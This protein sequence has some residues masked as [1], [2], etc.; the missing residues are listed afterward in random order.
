MNNQYSLETIASP[1]FAIGSEHDL[2]L[3]TSSRHLLQQIMSHTRE[4]IVVM[5][6]RGRVLE[7]NDAF[8]HLTELDAATVTGQH[9]THISG[10]LYPR[11]YYCDLWQELQRQEQWQGEMQRY[12]RHGDLVTHGLML[13]L[14]R[15]RQAQVSYI[16]GMLEDIS[17]LKDS[18]AQLSYLAHHDA[19]TGCANRA[20]LQHWFNATTS[21]TPSE[22]F[23]FLFID[24]DRFKPINDSFGHEVGD[25]VLTVLARRL[26]ALAD[27]RDLVTRLGGDEF[28]M[29]YRG[30]FTDSALAA[31]AQQVLR[32]LSKPVN[33]GHYVLNLGASVGMSVYPRDGQDFDSLL[34][35]ADIAMYHAKRYRDSHFCQFE[36]TF[37]AKIE[38]QQRL[39]SECSI[40]LEQGAFFLQYQPVFSADG[41]QLQYLEVLVRWHHPE[42]GILYPEQILAAVKAAGLLYRLSEWV[43]LTAGRQLSQWRS[44][45][46]WQGRVSIN[47]SRLE[48]EQ[49]KAKQLLDQLQQLGVSPSQ[50]NLELCSDYMMDCSAALRGTVANLRTAG[51]GIYLNKLGLGAVNFSQLGQLSLDGIK[52]DPDLWHAAYAPWTES[53]ISALVLLAKVRELKVTACGIEQEP[54]WGK[55][56]ALGCDHVQGRL[57]APPATSAALGNPAVL[58]PRTRRHRSLWDVK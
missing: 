58:E 56:Q 39:V 48:L 40:A 9:I 43:F 36:P 17:R 52:L 21:A 34:R 14:L 51:M 28:L 42:L 11:R 45:Y 33:L 18:E 19:L 23:A 2:N 16:I 5:D 22:P 46:Q 57:L 1:K 25:Q 44:Q 20:F 35:Y 47:L 10:E 26:Q 6:A 49:L 29:V 53:V 37:M 12:N 41:D 3:A 7:V 8:C 24:L 55:A 32:V 13:K 54:Q 30:T 38:H 50:F 31:L 27:E 4:G 15:D